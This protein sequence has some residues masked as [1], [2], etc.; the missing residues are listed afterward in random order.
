[1]KRFLPVLIGG[2]VGV[3]HV[4]LS[5]AVVIVQCPR[6][7]NFSVINPWCYSRVAAL[8]LFLAHALKRTIDIPLPYLPFTFLIHILFGIAIGMTFALP[9]NQTLSRSTMLILITYLLLYA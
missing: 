2:F 6:A 9:R 5:L 4:I 8:L 7:L 1:M 3:V